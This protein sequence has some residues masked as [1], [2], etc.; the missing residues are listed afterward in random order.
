M[1]FVSAQVVEVRAWGTTVGAIA[2]TASRGLSFEFDP[3]WVRSG[4]EISPLMMPLAIRRV[5]SYPGL[6]RETWHGLPP[7]IADS[8]PDRFGNAIIDA[9]LAR[10][11]AAPGQATALDRLVYTGSR[12]MGAVE[13]VPDSGPLTPPPST[14]DIG[15]LV[16]AA[17][18]VIRGQLGSTTALQQLLSIGTS[19]GGARAKAVVN[20]HPYTGEVRP[21]QVPLDGYEGWLLKFDGVGSD[22]ELGTSHEYGRIEYAYSLMARAAGIDMMPTRLLEEGGRAHFMTR[23]FDR[24]GGMRRLHTQ[25]LCALSILDYNQRAAHDYAQLFQAIDAL[26]LGDDARIEAFRRLV[27]NWMAAN[28]DDH[29][30]NHGFLMD[31]R[32]T[33]SLSP[34][35]DVTHAF[36]PDGEWT[37][38]HLMSVGGKFA[39]VTRF[40]LIEFAE[41][42]RVPGAGALISEVA[43]AVSEWSL[44]AAEAGLSAETTEHVRRDFH[45]EQLR[46]R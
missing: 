9:E 32:G 14:L 7:A 33:W 10:R 13:F 28:C 38:Q 45:V 4:L 36:N 17:R 31:E 25:T 11:G 1:D 2:R 37:Y 16:S 18:D 43:D 19:A 12:A 24:P 21:G 15:E 23:R 44:F 30:K 6:N 34:A 26:G 35:Y 42:H 20:V 29:T 8:L 46:R 22:S 40:D 27:F 41:R 5:Y 3:G 39:G